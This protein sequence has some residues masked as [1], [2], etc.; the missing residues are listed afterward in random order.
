MPLSRPATK[1]A[2]G[3]ETEKTMNTMHAGHIAPEHRLIAE[4][5]WYE[6]RLQE[7]GNGAESAYEKALARSFEQALIAQRARLAALRTG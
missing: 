4:I 5:A 2:D 1:V 6:A 3:R 7:L